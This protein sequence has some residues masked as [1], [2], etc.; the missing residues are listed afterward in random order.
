MLKIHLNISLIL[1]L[2]LF[3]NLLSFLYPVMVQKLIDEGFIKKKF[4][5]IVCYVAILAGIIIIREITEI[6]RANFLA[7]LQ[8]K[9][10][11]SLYQDVFDKITRIRM[12]FF[13]QKE[14]I[15]V[16]EQISTDIEYLNGMFWQGI[17][18]G[19]SQ[20][21]QVITGLFG[22][23]IINWKLAL[24][25]LIVIPVDYI[26]VKFFSDRQQKITDKL[27][28]SSNMFFS[29]FG[30]TISGIR[31]L[32][33]WNAK[34]FKEQELKE[35]QGDTI[36]WAKKSLMM[37]QY[38]TSFS[39]LI[40][41]GM[42]VF[43]YL[44]GGGLVCNNQLTV[45]GI[46]AFVTYCQYVFG[47]IHSIINIRYIFSRILPSAKRLFDVY[48]YP[49]E[50]ENKSDTRQNF[51]RLE[52]KD[53]SFSYSDDKILEHVN[54]TISAGEKV[55]I[56]GE[57]GTGKSTFLDLIL[58]FITPDD[59]EI[60][61]NGKNIEK[62]DIHK[63]RELFSVVEQFPYLF[64]DTIENNINLSH[65][66]TFD[67]KECITEENILKLIQKMPK[68]IK[69][70]LNSNGENLSGGERQKIAIARMLARQAPII[71]LDEAFSNCDKRSEEEICDYIYN[72]TL[73]RTVIFI[74]HNKEIRNVDKIL[75]FEN[76]I[77]REERQ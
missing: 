63:Y 9:V 69:T 45:G 2:F 52:F 43:F 66:K 50:Y 28:Y 60:L 11:L 74:T 40:V 56:I 46:L 14:T 73:D 20:I 10:Q 75:K 34:D 54:M 24:G 72:N 57:N 17:F 49:E 15:E 70:L 18:G 26:F 25:A 64:S 62:I 71:I 51:Q 67:L 58:R 65:M 32:K 41:E 12:S 3:L 13:S 4:A 44:L 42:V 76:G 48:D 21:L 23:F 53:I 36:K 33:L 7:D 30:D 39:S 37:E 8:N 5:D 59:G 29:W 16:V 27:L 35:R 55:A 19:I 38:N 31:E 68:G 22:L 61:L 77:I 47:P 6:M 1:F